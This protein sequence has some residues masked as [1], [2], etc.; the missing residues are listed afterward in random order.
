MK[1]NTTFG[2]QSPWPLS[3]WLEISK[4]GAIVHVSWLGNLRFKCSLK[5]YF[6]LEWLLND[7]FSDQN[8]LLLIYMS[9]TCIHI[10]RRLAT[11][12][13]PEDFNCHSWPRFAYVPETFAKDFL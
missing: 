3:L 4:K 6:I 1:K 11:S 9:S 5:Y 12:P 7:L 2:V 8:V 10:E 13:Y